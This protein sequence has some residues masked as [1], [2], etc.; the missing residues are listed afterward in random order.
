MTSLP[1]EYPCPKHPSETIK[2]VHYHRGSKRARTLCNTCYQRHKSPEDISSAIRLEELL[3]QTPFKDA[4]ALIQL[5]K[6]REVH[7]SKEYYEF[8]EQL[9][10]LWLKYILEFDLLFRQLKKNQE[11][12]L[13]NFI[14]PGNELVDQC[15]S[16]TNNAN[17]LITK[18]KN[19]FCEG[20]VLDLYVQEYFKLKTLVND[21]KTEITYKPQKIDY[22]SVY[23]N[24]S[25]TLAEIKNTLAHQ[26]ESYRTA[27]ENAITSATS[28]DYRYLSLQKRFKSGFNEITCFQYFRELDKIIIGGS[29]AWEN[30]MAFIGV[31]ESTSQSTIKTFKAHTDVISCFHY[32]PSRDLLASA[33]F[34]KTINVWNVGEDYKSVRSLKAEGGVLD[35]EYIEGENVLLA[36]GRFQGVKVWT[37]ETFMQKNSLKTKEKGIAKIKY[38]AKKGWLAVAGFDGQLSVYGWHNKSLLLSL[39]SHTAYISMI[40]ENPIEKLLFTS[41]EEGLLTVWDIEAYPIVR[42]TLKLIGE[43]IGD[44]CVIPEEGILMSVSWTPRNDELFLKAWDYRTG[45]LLSEHSV[46]GNLPCIGARL[47]YNSKLR[48]LFVA[49]ISSGAIAI[50]Q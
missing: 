41:G 47:C 1:Y 38:L 11:E 27:M 12:Q 22:K 8:S 30:S 13:L 46:F 20:E 7:L 34:D 31:M 23:E 44:F 9:H 42:R 10:Q 32:I 28:K 36:C 19:N 16:T 15:R 24:S 40:H 39:K 21:M 25:A 6:E 50:L 2:Y 45:R 14:L 49:D 18:L 17:T 3:S 4:E 35:L 48:K 26:L 37:C 33:S 29:K 43:S 5:S